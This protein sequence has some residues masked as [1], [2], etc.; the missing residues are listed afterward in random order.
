MSRSLHVQQHCYL[1][2]LWMFLI[3]SIVRFHL[4]ASENKDVGFPPLLVLS[5]L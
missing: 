3:E 4:E 2:L 1:L 5:A